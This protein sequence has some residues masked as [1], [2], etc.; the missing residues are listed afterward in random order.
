MKLNKQI[1]KQLRIA[2][3]N[4]KSFDVL[5]SREVWMPTKLYDE[6]TLTKFFLDAGQLHHDHTGPTLPVY[7]VQR[8]DGEVHVVSAGLEPSNAFPILKKYL[9]PEVKAV[10]IRCDVPAEYL[11]T[12]ERGYLNSEYGALE[13]LVQHHPSGDAR[14]KAIALLMEM[15]KNEK[16]N[17]SKP[18]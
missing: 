17:S 16:E 11:G 6:I 18:H 2:T 10:V 13:F 1:A 5:T 4:M 15:A 3:G 14:V 8:Q 7:F 9:D 12:H